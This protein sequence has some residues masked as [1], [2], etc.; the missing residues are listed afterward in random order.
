[1]AAVFAPASEVAAAVEEQCAASGDPRLA[2][3]AD[4]GAHLMVSGP[5]ADVEALLA[6]FEAA[7]GASA[8]AWRGARAT[9]AP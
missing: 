9:T 3:A 8:A 6:R 5:T 2:I 1:M 4:N 7:G